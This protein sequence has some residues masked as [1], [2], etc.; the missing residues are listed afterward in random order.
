MKNDKNGEPSLEKIDDYN[1]KESKE[2][3]NTVKLVIIVCLLAGA[4]LSFLKFDNKEVSDYV[5]TKEA[6]GI[7]STKK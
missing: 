1:N 6:P 5:G 2:K 7:T 3:R 4:V